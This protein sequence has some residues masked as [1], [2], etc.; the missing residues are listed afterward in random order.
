MM[1]SSE[2]TTGGETGLFKI[3][4]DCNM[5]W[6]TGCGAGAGGQGSTGTPGGNGGGASPCIIRWPLK[7]Q[8][9]GILAITVGAA[10]AGGS[11]GHS[12]SLSSQSFRRHTGLVGRALLDP[13]CTPEYPG[14]PFFIIGWGGESSSSYPCVPNFAYESF[15]Q[16]PCIATSGNPPQW[17]N[18]SVSGLWPWMAGGPASMADVARAPPQNSYMYGVAG[19]NTLNGYGHGNS[20]VS[21]ASYSSGG[22]G[23]GGVFGQGGDGGQGVSGGTANNGGAATGYGAGGGGGSGV[24]GGSSSGGAGSGGYLLIEY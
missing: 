19:R 13:T 14:L 8:P 11:G 24:S 12:A 2:W 7:V 17:I 4:S 18:K 22:S 23:G 20:L 21:D 3:P 1:R 15:S 16:T 9:N 6:V 10:T 5:I